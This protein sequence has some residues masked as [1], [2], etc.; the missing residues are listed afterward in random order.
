M[1]ALEMQEDRSG[2]SG[3]LGTLM[4]VS[5]SDRSMA[6]SQS[7]LASYQDL[8]T[9]AG[10]MSLERTLSA[11]CSTPFMPGSQQSCSGYMASSSSQEPA[12]VM[13]CKHRVW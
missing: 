11:L 1:S 5:T 13:G 10:F 9:I 2:R 6:S 3:L 8:N 4:T 12:E 7:L